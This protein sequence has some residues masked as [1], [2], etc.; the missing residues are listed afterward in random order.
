MSEQRARNSTR[1]G[2]SDPALNIVPTSINEAAIH[3]GGDASRHQGAWLLSA[4]AMPGT[5]PAYPGGT[6]CG[7]RAAGGTIDWMTVSPVWGAVAGRGTS[8]RN[9][10]VPHM[11]RMYFPNAARRIGNAVNFCAGSPAEK[12]RFAM[13]TTNQI[14]PEFSRKRIMGSIAA[15]A[16]AFALSTGTARAG[17]EK[18]SPEL[19]SLNAGIDLDVIVQYKTA[20]SAANHEKIAALGGRLHSE[21]SHV[22]AA[23]YTIPRAGVRTLSEDPDVAYISPNRPLKG[24]LNITA[25]TVH[26]NVANTEGYTGTG[27]GVAII[28]SGISDMAEFHNGRSRIVY[29]QSFVQSAAPL[30]LGCPDGGAQVGAWY[31]DALHAGGGVAPYSFSISAGSLPA[32]LSLDAAGNITG[33]PTTATAT[34]QSFTSTVTDSYGNTASQSCKLKVGAATGGWVAP[35][36]LGCVIAGTQATTWYDSLLSPQGGDAPYTFS[37]VSGSLPAG[38]TLNAS[39]GAI[40][41]IPAT[42]S[43]GPPGNFTIKMTDSAGYSITRGCSLYVAPAPQASMTGPADQ[44]GHG[45]HVAGIVGSNGAGEVYIGIAPAVNLVSLRVLD[46]NGNGTDAN[47]IQAIDAAISLARNYNIRVINLSLGRHVFEPA[48]QDPLCQA[49]EAAWHA[50]IVVVVAAGNGGRSNSEGNQGYGTITAPG[51][52]PCAITVGAMKSEGT[53]TRTD[54]LIASYSS[55]GPTAFDHYAKPDIVAPGN[56]IV[57]TMPASMTLSEEY[58]I[59][60]RVN[61]DFFTLSGTSMATPVVSGAAVLLL[62]KTPGL[63]PDQVKARLMLTATRNFPASSAA[64][65]PVTD[66]AYTSY[67]DIFTIGAGYLDIAAALNDRTALTG[68]SL[69]PAA[70]YSASTGDIT[71]DGISVANLPEGTSVIWGT[72]AVSGT[73]VIWG[74][75]VI[76]GTSVILGHGRSGWSEY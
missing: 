60:N 25:P 37:I 65:D 29:Q 75:T 47:V 46:E 64:V 33:I 9:D 11:E 72:Q 13:K 8:G 62:Q 24:M 18:L 36:H 5:T 66:I 44:Y 73:H 21:M 2:A 31:G 49:V 42:A 12:A 4:A 76:W 6:I 51:N 15:V 19:K 10:A 45:S 52:D 23:H 35:E 67:Y 3:V 68:T 39:N 54:D 1:S 56:L 27:I 41:G 59:A 69:S 30:S 38:L 50:G 16:L 17:D 32:G 40:Y 53:V 26:S 74:T 7:Y 61:S 57:S 20:P 43:P 48:A 28:D 22:Q 58:S 63:T 55:K 14:R 71:L 34:G 70:A